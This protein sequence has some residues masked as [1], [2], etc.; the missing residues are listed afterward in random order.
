MPLHHKQLLNNVKLYIHQSFQ[1][2]QEVGFYKLILS[3]K[4]LRNFIFRRIIISEDQVERDF[5][6]KIIKQV[7]IGFFLIFSQY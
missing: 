3:V 5:H 4:F 2:H 7:L 1:V 6:Y